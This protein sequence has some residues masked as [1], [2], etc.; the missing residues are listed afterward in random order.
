MNEMPEFLLDEANRLYAKMA[1][2][3][4]SDIG[5]KLRRVD[6]PD[7]LLKSWSTCVQ[8]DPWQTIKDALMKV[9]IVSHASNR[10]IIG[11]NSTGPSIGK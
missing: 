10:L 6:A 5:L 3:G 8:I 7:F 11:I 2:L 9:N 4:E 1:Q